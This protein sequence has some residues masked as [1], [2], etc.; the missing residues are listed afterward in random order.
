ML[1]IFGGELRY[2]ASRPLAWVLIVLLVAVSFGLAGG[3]LTI[4]SGDTT[5][6]GEAKAWITSEYAVGK[7]FPL[8][9]FLLYVF[10]VSIACGMAIIR[11]DELQVGPLLHATRLRPKEYVWAKFAAT[12]T[13]FLSILG[14]HVLLQIVF[15]HFAPNPQAEEIRGPLELGN[16]LRPALV[17]ALPCIVFFAGIAFAIGE[18]TRRPILIF[19]TPVVAFLGTIFF[20][21][22]WS[23]TWLDPR[24][25]RLLMWIEPSG[26]RWITETWIK[27]DRGVEFYNMQPIDYDAPFLLSRL[28]FLALGLLSV[29][30]AARHFALSLRGEPVRAPRAGAEPTVDV[31]AETAVMASEEP[32]LSSLGNAASRPGFLRSM[33]HVAAFEARNLAS[34]PGLYLFAPLILLQTLGTDSLRLGAFD[35]QILLTSGTGAVGSM[36][37]L[38]LLVCL[39]LLFYTTESAL[40]ER[41]LG[42]APVIYA[43]PA[44]TA[45][46]LA[47]KAIANAIVGVTILLGAALGLSIIMLVQGEVGFEPRPFLLVWGL[48]LV[49]TFMVWSAFVMA[50]VAFT[51][52]RY[53]TYGIGLGVMAYTGWKLQL[54]EVNWVGNW[55]LWST[56]TWT[57]FG[58]LEPNVSALLLN[59]LFYLAVMVLL[60]ALTVRVFPR[61]EHDSAQI[62][63]S[64]R[65]RNLLRLGLYLS[66]AW[67]PALVLGIALH[68]SV[69]AGFQGEA[70]EQRDQDY[71][72]RNLLTWQ[73]AEIPSIAGVEIDLELAPAERSFHVSGWYDLV[74][75]AKDHVTSFPMSI[76]DHFENVEW[77]LDGEPFE[78][79]S[80]A[81]L[82]VFNLEQPLAPG[83]K[84]RVGF[85]HDGSFPKGLTKNGGGM[86]NFILPSGVVLTSLNTGFLPVPAFEEGRGVDED[87]RT[88]PK[89]FEPDFYLGSTPPALGT[90]ARFPAKMTISGP[91]EY[92]Y[93]GVGARVSDKI[94]NGQRTVVWE[95]DHPV[96]FFNVVAARW[97]EWRADGVAIYHHPDH[98][99]NI[100]KMGE[101]LVAARKHY[102]EWFHPYPWSELKL[103]EFP[104]LAFYA[105]G[106]P[107]N[108]TFSEH[109]GFLTRDTVEADA[110]FMVTAHE[111]AHQWWGNILMPGKGPGGNIL[112]E[113]MAHFSTALLFEEVRGAEA[114]MGFLKRIEARYGEARRVDEEKPLARTLGDKPADN[115]VIYD[116]GGWVFYMLHNLMGEE[117][118][119]AGIQA[120]ISHYAN[121]DDD[122]PV[123]QDYVRVLREHAP[124]LE[125]YDAFV[126]QWFFD[127]EVPE[128]RLS[129]VEKSDA[130]GGWVVTATLENR[131]TG[132]TTVEIAATRGER[133]PDADAAQS[134]AYEE[135]RTTVTLDEGERVELRIPSDF[136][137]QRLVVDPDVQ[138]LMLQ[139]NR[140]LARLQSG[141]L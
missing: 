18:R 25:N 13:T 77:T 70:A 69:Q 62:I 112:S 107:T 122:Y 39:L 24:I 141:F 42:L 134:V 31:E 59:R 94:T 66:P 1:T 80:R 89:D 105:Q 52:D 116:K 125:A 20:L 85:S 96:R 137:P 21:F 109:I 129:D 103:S 71:W 33:L 67:I 35:T 140:A 127:V 118:S 90:G 11:D 101:T 37:T 23:P 93:H 41:H 3:N 10:F 34:Q 45:A 44:P 102:S 99:Y 27:V 133:F 113:G 2:N 16:Y 74:N 54:G 51:G 8:V 6:G 78:P 58:G 5:V 138:V 128:Y 131:G 81:R 63:D 88:E 68:V 14:V 9:V 22:E 106:F 110:V 30:Y 17:F 28:V 72:G 100:E 75:D 50:V 12:L 56:T 95:T 119:L 139:R 121:V 61:R 53:S 36:N 97:N 7:M 48:L 91:A 83:A 82:H 84:V 120:F 124:D 64:L 55:I 86:G 29:A 123:L 130:S 126:E 47:G 132:R 115:T 79:E 4:S 49:P 98:V 73:D 136:E 114:R 26:F 65:P 92:G 32:A 15:N 111:T 43:T 46:L 19:L 135:A 60:V 87:N 57:D 40:R 104:G 117:A 38:S 76:G 108:I